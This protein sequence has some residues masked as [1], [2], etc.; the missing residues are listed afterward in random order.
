MTTATKF[1]GQNDA[2]SRT[3]TT[4]ICENLVL[5]VALVSESKALYCTV[6]PRLTAT[7]VYG[8]LVITAT[9]FGPAKRP[10]ISLQK[11]TVIVQFRIK[12]YR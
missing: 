11:K 10:Y 2:A 7:S 4:Y 5:V 12:N 9:V 1:S 8:H 6:E 3:S